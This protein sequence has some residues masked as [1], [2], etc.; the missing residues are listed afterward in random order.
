MTPRQTPVRSG[1]QKLSAS[2]PDREVN[3]VGP[4]RPRRYRRYPP[5]RPQSNHQSRRASSP[6]CPANIASPPRLVATEPRK[7]ACKR[8]TKKKE[9]IPGIN[10]LH[11]LG[12][13]SRIK[14]VCRGCTTELSKHIRTIGTHYPTQPSSGTVCGRPRDERPHHFPIFHAERILEVRLDRG[15]VHIHQIVDS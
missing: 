7:N 14:R 8:E 11:R 6:L 9:V 12:S 13:C 1:R 10:T 5:G 2:T 15:D 4:R 3:T